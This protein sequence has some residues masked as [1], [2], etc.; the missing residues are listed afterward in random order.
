MKSVNTSLHLSGG[1]AGLV[2]R[3]G[4]QGNGASTFPLDIPGLEHAFGQT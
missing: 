1:H 4:V 3:I 2:L